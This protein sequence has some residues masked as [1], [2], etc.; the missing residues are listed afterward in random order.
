MTSFPF[1]TWTYPEQTKIKHK[2]FR[3]YFDKWVK[4]LGRYH[5]FNYI[6]CF[7]GAGAYKD[8][9]KIYYGSPILAA[10][11]IKANKKTATLVVI[12]DN[13]KNLENL[14][15]I[16][17][18]EKL[19]DL[20]IIPVN[21]DFDKTI[22]DILDQKQN[23]APTFFF[24]DPWGFDISYSTLKRIMKVEKSEIFLNFQFNALNRFL[25]STPLEKTT[26]DLFGTDKWKSLPK[27]KGLE[28]ENSILN[29]YR[30][31]LEKIA[32]FVFPFKVQ[33]PHKDRTYYYLFHL[34]NYWKGCSIMKSC[35]AKHA[36]GRLEYLGDRSSQ[37]RLF[38]IGSVKADE[39]KQLFLE[40]YDGQS[41]T[42]LDV[43]K[44]NISK[45]KFLE[46]EIKNCLKQL[47]SDGIVF[48]ERNPKTTEKIRRL[49]SSLVEN[50]TFHF[51]NPPSITRK[52]LLYKTKV[53]YGNFTINHVLGCAHGCNYPCYARMLA[54]KYGQIENYEDWMHPRIVSNALELLDKE[55]PKYKKEIDF[56]HLS[57]TTDPFMYDLLNKRTFP[58]IN[59]LT[60]KIV[61]KLNSN[62]IKCTILTKGLYPKVLSSNNKFSNENEYGITLVSLNE[63]FKRQ[64]E[65]YSA[66][67]S[68]RL[69]SLKYLHEKGLKTWV[70]IEPYPTPNIVTQDLEKILKQISF[71]DKIIFGKMNYNVHSNK[72]SNNKQFYKECAE[73]VI[74]FCKKK[75]IK[76]HIKEG[77]PYSTN[78]TKQIFQRRN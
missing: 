56:V 35:F 40:K 49:R 69:A 19:T 42:Y 67:L 33:F 65:P 58:H 63:K 72:F 30:E 2:V 15:K 47:E 60:L 68:D 51:N 25:S 77:T 7:A 53:E 6:D 28:R 9:D 3:E 39:V 70:S 16:F 37:M 66:P 45:T 12:D 11:I 62:G 18:Y 23:L 13:K 43:I 61:K 50:D 73:K 52:T 44:E 57:F 55:I 34:T 75:E 71:V 36:H 14:E 38:E 32:E 4:I 64:Y 8:N 24:I 1:T 41:K 20:T 74:D 22:N 5:K 21:Q 46:S 27:L 76:Y 17:E 78:H 59:E 26:T 54:I 29:L 31:Q 10:K 48:I